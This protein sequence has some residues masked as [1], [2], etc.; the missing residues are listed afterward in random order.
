MASITPSLFFGEFL[1]KKRISYE[2]VQKDE[3]TIYIFD[4]IV[5]NGKNAGKTVVLGLPIPYD[6][7]QNAPYGMHI[8]KNHGLEGKITNVSK[9]I[10]GDEWDL[11]SRNV[12]NWETN[13]TAQYYFDHV[14]RWL[15]VE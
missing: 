5:P 3:K 14:N 7:P 15:E 10:L 12:N 4:H 1:T 6:F 9:S 2:A 8:K 13:R 11:W